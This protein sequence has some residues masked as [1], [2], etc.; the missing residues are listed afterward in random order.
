MDWIRCDNVCNEAIISNDYF[1]LII[2]ISQGIESLQE[3]FEPACIQMINTKYA[4]IYISRERLPIDSLPFSNYKIHNIPRLLGNYGEI[5]L[6]KSGILGFHEHPYIPLRGTGTIVGIVST[7]IDYTHPV[8][9]YEDNSTKIISIWDQ[10]IEGSP[11]EGFCYGSEY[12]A[13]IINEALANDNPYDIVPERDENGHGT[14]LAGA[15]AGRADADKAFVGAAP[16]AEI[17]TVKL[18]RPKPYMMNMF[19]VPEDEWA[20][21]ENDLMLGVEYILRKAASEMKPV[22]IIIGI[23]TTLGNHSGDS[24]IERYLN[25]VSINFGVVTVIAAGNEGNRGHHF[26]GQLSKNKLDENVLLNVENGEAGLQFTMV[27]NIPDIITLS[28]IA[29]NGFVIERKEPVVSG[30]ETYSIPLEFTKVH[31]RYEIASIPRGINFIYVSLERP[32][33]GIWTLRVFG[34]VIIGGR[35]DIW[36][37]REG[38]IKPNTVF[39]R[40][41]PFTTITIPGTAISPITV[42][43]YNHLNDSLYISSS[44]GL[45]F[46]MDLKPEICAPGVNVMGPLPGGG[47]GQMTGTSVAS[48]ITG[49]AAVLLLEWGIVLGNDLDMSTVKVKNW[50]I[51]GAVRKQDLIYPN[52]EW[53]YGQLNLLSAYEKLRSIIGGTNEVE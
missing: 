13:V 12:N 8:F 17:L 48:A 29:P 2:D 21:Q 6:E 14:F 3:I 37:S 5:V 31:I 30:I 53:G 50:L 39:L 22:V 51:R 32:I 24:F 16:D 18:K 44:R 35:F 10:T 19:Y 23:G 42:G 4:S 15:A 41:D 34:E 45:T 9:R 46:E 33:E 43:A 52:R 28:I 49:G 20:C 25:D 36:L 38:W 1:D 40:N 26:S 47:Y 7:G 11:P 27:S